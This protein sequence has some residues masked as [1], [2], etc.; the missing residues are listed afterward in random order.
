MISIL[1]EQNKKWKGSI[2][3]CKGE[4]TEFHQNDN[5]CLQILVINTLQE[6][7]TINTAVKSLH[8]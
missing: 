1:C 7:R 5:R 3:C 8:G 6:I 2:L 4:T